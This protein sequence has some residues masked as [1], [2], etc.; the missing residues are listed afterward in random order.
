V[1]ESPI[2]ENAITGVVIG[3]SLNGMRVI[4][5]HQR[6][7]FMLYAM[8]QIVNNAAKWYSMFGGQNGSVPIVIRCIIGRGWG[9]GN[10][11]SQNL[12]YIFTGMPG[13]KV[14]FPSNADNARGLLI[15]SWKDPNPVIFIEHR[16]CHNYKSKITDQEYPLG[17]ARVARVGYDITMVAWGYMLIETMKAADVLAEYGVDCEVIDLQTL[18]P[19]DYKTIKTSARKTK[20]LMI[21]EDSWEDSS[22]VY[23]IAARTGTRQSIIYC[24]Q[25][26]YAPATPGLIKGYYPS[27][28]G[29]VA[30][31]AKQF[32]L[33]INFDNLVSK[34]QD[35]PDSDFKGPF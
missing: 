31:M 34:Y 25:N 32:S 23:Q 27:W 15:S 12:S 17:K 4:H 2:S 21:I 3:A 9:Q 8:D 18:S 11:H 10:Q 19:I 24:N 6:M 16:W 30:T 26:D 20:N 22:I 13:L 33:R 7:D 35:V 14:V 5:I 28:D 29:I 1:F